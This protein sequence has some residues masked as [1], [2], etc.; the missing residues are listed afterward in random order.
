MTDGSSKAL[1]VTSSIKAA[2]ERVAISPDR[3]LV[4]TGSYDG[5]RDL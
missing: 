2:V 1:A 4:A 5:V 3:R